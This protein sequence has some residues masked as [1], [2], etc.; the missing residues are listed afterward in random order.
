MESGLAFAAGRDRAITA[1]ELEAYTTDE[2]PC[3]ARRMYNREQTPQ[4]VGPDKNRILVQ[5]EGSE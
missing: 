3:R 1:K 5:Y 2:V 4:V